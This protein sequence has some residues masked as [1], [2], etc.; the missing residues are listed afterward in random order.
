VLAV[1][2]LESVADPRRP[3]RPTGLLLR[4]PILQVP[5]VAGLDDA[6]IARKSGHGAAGQGHRRAVLVQEPS[7]VLHAGTVAWTTGVPKRTS[8]IH[9]SS[10]NAWVR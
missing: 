2:V 7:P 8:S 10:V 4:R 5:V 9:C 6:A 3:I 1:L